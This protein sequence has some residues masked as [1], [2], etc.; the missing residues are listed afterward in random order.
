[1][2]WQ[3]IFL[4]INIFITLTLVTAGYLNKTNSSLTPGVVI[5]F[6]NYLTYTSYVVIG[7]CDY[8]LNILKTRSAKQRIKEILD[9]K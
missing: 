3:L 9:L 8:V 4:A 2:M 6:L 7:I 5:A 1:M